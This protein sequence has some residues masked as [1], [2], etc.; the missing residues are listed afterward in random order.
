MTNKLL[1]LFC[2]LLAVP[3]WSQSPLLSVDVFDAETRDPLPFV[4]VRILE[5]N[6]GGTTDETGRFGTRLPPGEYRL[7]STFVGYRPDTTTVLLEQPAVVTV[8]L[9]PESATLRTVTV[10][11]NDARRRLERPQL[12]VEQLTVAELTTLPVAMGEIDVFRGIQTVSGVTSAGEASNGLSVRGGTVDQNLLLYDGAP[13]YTPTHLFGLFSV[14]T[15]DAIGGVNL[16][17]ANIPARHGGRLASVLSVDA[18]SPGSERFR[19]QGGVGLVSSRLAIETPLTRDKKLRVL[20][21]GRAGFNDF[22]FG[23]SERLK[24][25]RARFA[26]G[27]VKLRYLPDD[28]NI[29]SS[30]LFYSKDFYQIDLLNAFEDIIADANQY[31]YRTLNGTVEWLRLLGERTS[32]LTRLIRADHEPKILFPEVNSDNVVEFGSRIRSHHAELQ[33]DHRYP[34]GHQLSVGGQFIRYDLDPGALDPGSATSLNPVELAA[35]RGLELTAY[36][37]DEWIVGGALTL[38]AGLRYTHFANQGP[39][40]RRIYTRGEEVRAGTLE[41]TEELGSGEALASFGGFEPRLGASLRLTPRLR[42]KAAYAITRQYLQNIY[43]STTPLPTSR[44]LLS[45][46]NVTPQRASLGSAGLFMLFG[47]GGLELSLEAYYR[48]TRNLLEYKPGAEFF[49]NRTVETDVLQ[50]RGRAY[51]FEIGLKKSRGKVT[52]RVNY[53]YARSRNLVTGDNFRTRINGGQWYNGYFDQPHTLN[54]LLS[55]N[56]EKNTLGFTLVVQSNRPYTVPNG[57]VTLDNLTVPLFLE[58]NNDRLPLYHRLD[59]N[60]TL[61]NFSLKKRRWVG[62]WTV[63]VYNLYG[64]KNAYNIFYQPRSAT[65]GDAGVFGNSPLASYKLSIFT[66]PVVS[67]SYS[68]KFE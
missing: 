67:L 35:E 30:T 7:V 51:G 5:N 65:Q 58:R 1:T 52:T 2:W 22:L 53:T 44:W 29:F 59:F 66:N 61:H 21:A 40:E 8:E 55:I 46:D 26:D 41:E 32:V 45:D 48:D 11:A 27:T 63:T 37:E 18:R 34:S 25:T 3:G 33:L 13:V 56:G 9:I 38:S 39:G 6:Q 68:F 62:D 24:N 54:G 19:M 17:R 42:F 12:G 28:K 23:L 50:G 43:N 14:F 20:A 60:W 57:V 10:T 4:S 47:N 16:Y 15:P 49:L 31:D 36:V 64:R